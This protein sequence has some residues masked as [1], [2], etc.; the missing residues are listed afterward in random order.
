M[1][2][3]SCGTW[4]LVPWTGVVVVQLLS[5]VWL[6]AILWAE[7]CQASL[8]FTISQSLLRLMSIESV[9]LSNHLIL[10]HPLLLLPSIF[11]GIRVFSNEFFASGGQVSF[12]IN[13]LDLLAGD[14]SCAYPQIFSRL[15]FVFS[16]VCSSRATFVALSA[17]RSP[18][19]DPRRASDLNRPVQTWLD[20]IAS[21][22]RLPLVTSH[23]FLT[24]CG[25]RYSFKPAA[26][27]WVLGSAED[28]ASASDS[29]HC[30]RLCL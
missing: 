23:L 9:M 22:S 7:G 21:L 27:H 5:H 25:L 4:D 12:R 18:S 1:R 30:R 17:A 14:R 6:L 26:Q 13:W 11:P 19:C 24:S 3:L 29:H 28:K 16:C 8:S 20:W 10:C 2:T 15:S